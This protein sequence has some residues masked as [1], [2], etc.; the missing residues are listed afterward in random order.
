ML[1][2][3]AENEIEFLWN[4]TF[5]QYLML[6]FRL[7]GTEWNEFYVFTQSEKY[8]TLKLDKHSRFI[9]GGERLSSVYFFHIKMWAAGDN[10]VD[11]NS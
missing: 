6:N 11:V 4:V 9:S 5:A 8:K 1:S 2:Y 7:I 10:I 3:W